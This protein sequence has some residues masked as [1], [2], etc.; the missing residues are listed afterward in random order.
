M[1][2]TVAASPGMAI[3]L[4]PIIGIALSRYVGGRVR[5]SGNHATVAAVSRAKLALILRWPLDLPV[6]IA[7]AFVAKHL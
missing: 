6:F 4:Y 1:A 2:A 3:L 5:W 7:Q